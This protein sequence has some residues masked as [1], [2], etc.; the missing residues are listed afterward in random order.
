MVT[1]I[2]ALFAI[3]VLMIQ[4]AE[5]TV[6]NEDVL[7]KIDLFHSKVKSQIQ[8][9][10]DDPYAE[11]RQKSTK[12]IT[13][14]FILIGVLDYVSVGIFGANSADH[15][16]RDKK[17]LVF[18][19]MIMIII[20]GHYNRVDLFKV[21]LVIAFAGAVAIYAL[22]NNMSHIGGADL[23]LAELPIGLVWKD[24]F[25]VLGGIAF[26]GIII[27]FVLFAKLIS[28]ILYLII[29]LAFK[30]CLHLSPKKPLKVLI[31]MVECISILGVA[32]MGIL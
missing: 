21:G 19:V 5:S 28:Y 23:L 12:W 4:K 30:L 18:I 25:V 24:I 31:V 11:T 15:L 32:I 20:I 3:I 26:L 29:R 8:G 10:V 17:V 27:L 13:F 14:L 7:V 16:L 9:I 2:I 1:I 6:N 22:H